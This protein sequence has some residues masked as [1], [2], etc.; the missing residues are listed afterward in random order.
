MNWNNY[1]ELWTVEHLVSLSLFNLKNEDDCKLA[2]NH[3]N[4]IPVLIEDIY[5]IKDQ[6]RFSLMW[7]Q[8]MD[9]CPVVNKLVAILMKEIEVQDIYIRVNGN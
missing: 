4:L 6:Y 2:W 1:G 9:K 7:F 5:S 3:K 8:K